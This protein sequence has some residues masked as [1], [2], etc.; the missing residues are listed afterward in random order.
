MPVRLCTADS[1]FE[2][3]FATFLGTKRESAADVTEDALRI[4]D[5]VRLRGDAAVIAYAERFD[6]QRLTPNSLRVP[7]AEILAAAEKAPAAAREALTVAA[8]RIDEFHIQQMPADLELGGSDGVG[9]GYR[10]SPITSVGLY[11]PGGLAAYPSTVLMTAIPA[12]VAGVDRIAM[13]TVSPD[14]A[15]HP[16]VA[17]AAQLSG[18]TEI[19]RVGGAHAVAALALGTDSIPAVDKI[20]GPGNAYVTAA[21]RLLFG[22]VGIDMVAG[23]SEILVVADR[24]NDPAWVAADLLSQAEHDTNAQAILMTD[25]SAF[26][27][28]VEGAIADHL[29][30]LERASIA[31]AAWKEYGAIILLDDLAEAPPLIDRIAPEHLELAVAKPESVSKE[32]RH[33]GAIFL[34]RYTPEAVG[35][36]IAGPSHVLP[37]ARSAR[38]SSGLSVL[39][40]MKR[41]SLV[42]CDASGLR[43]VGPAAAELAESEG[44]G[45]HALSLN[46]RLSDDGNSES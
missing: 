32:V 12:G 10:W 5:D 28:Q 6:D 38:F 34:G 27:G 33:A 4:I 13:V 23:P 39:D 29:A 45:A 43:M 17:A 26:A 2:T 35:D 31:S 44:F 18:V 9:L 21:K 42:R 22:S 46:I 19:Y 8:Q 24:E 15:L 40:F 7:E 16:M 1:N 11:I 20:V 30:R 3:E 37:T 41:T 36:Y 25:D 14:D